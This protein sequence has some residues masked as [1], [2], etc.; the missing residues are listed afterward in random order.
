VFGSTL[1]SARGL[2]ILRD[3]GVTVSDA[4][5]DALI[6]VVRE[7]RAVPYGVRVALSDVSQGSATTSVTIALGRSS[8]TAEE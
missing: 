2:R 1:K 6:A 7:A 4:A 8:L 3:S 5:R